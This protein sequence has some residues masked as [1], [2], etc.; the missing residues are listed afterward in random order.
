MK[1]DKDNP[2][3]STGNWCLDCGHAMRYNVPRLGPNGGFIH[4][5][6]NQLQC[7]PRKE[8]EQNI[9]YTLPVAVVCRPD[10]LE[11]LL[12]AAMGSTTKELPYVP[13]FAGLAVHEKAGQKEAWKYFYNV[14]ELYNYLTENGK[15]PI[16]TKNTDFAKKLEKARNSSK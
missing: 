12:E 16:S 14:D 15:I 10:F 3:K 1:V 2:D 6:T 4:A 13:D 8:P 9:A 5:D 7:G 11:T